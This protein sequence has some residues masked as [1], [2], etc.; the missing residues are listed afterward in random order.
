MKEQSLHQIMNDMASRLEVL[1]V[2]ASSKRAPTPLS[3][4]EAFMQIDD[5]L[6]SLNKDYLEAKAQRI[7]LVA[8][9]GSEDAMVE[10]IMDMEDS[11]WCAMQT[12]Y[13]ELRAERELMERAQRLMRRAEEKIEEEKLR[14]KIYEAHQF[15]YFVKILEKVKEMNK[16]PKIFEWAFLL[17]L[18]K[19]EPF[20]D[21]PDYLMKQ[22]MAA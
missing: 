15:A 16:T 7:E 8:L 13:L 5:L 17:L 6:M 18:F 20:H 4:L 21:R 12:R 19:L 10:V 11:A 2:P 9:Y 14:E 22:A 3:E 1:H